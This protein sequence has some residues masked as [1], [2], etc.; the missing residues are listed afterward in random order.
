MKAK[1][2]LAFLVALLLLCVYAAA[3][4]AVEGNMLRAVFLTALSSYASVLVF[5]GFAYYNKQARP[6]RIRKR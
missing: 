6:V 4:N 3:S 5:S 2:L 1:A